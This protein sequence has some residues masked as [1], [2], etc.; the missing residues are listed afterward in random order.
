MKFYIIANSATN[1]YEY[2]RKGNTRSSIT[3]SFKNSQGITGEI[4]LTIKE[5]APNGKLTAFE[6]PD[7]NADIV[8]KTCVIVYNGA[9]YRYTYRFYNYKATESIDFKTTENVEFALS[10]LSEEV[11]RVVGFQSHE[12][13]GTFAEGTTYYEVSYVKTTDTAIVPG[14]TYY[15]ESSGTYTVVADPQVEDLGDYYEVSYVKTTDTAI[16]PGKTYY[17]TKN[18]SYHRLNK[19][20]GVLRNVTQISLE[21]IPSAGVDEEFYVKVGDDYYL[22]T[23]HFTKQA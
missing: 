23:F 19:E 12:S 20:T 6:E 8:N 13:L 14:K 2:G 4:S 7:P 22:I 9:N 17:T 21:T 5:I 18:V 3:A 15:T 11:N 1:F 16:V 10:N